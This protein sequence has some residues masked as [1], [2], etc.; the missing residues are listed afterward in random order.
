MTN[1]DSRFGRWLM[2]L[3]EGVWW[4]HGYNDKDNADPCYCI[5]LTNS[6]LEWW[7][8]EK[9]NTDYVLAVTRPCIQLLFDGWRSINLRWRTLCAL[10]QRLR[11]LWQPLTR[12]AVRHADTVSGWSFRIMR[13]LL[14]SHHVWRCNN[15]YH[16][17]NK[18]SPLWWFWL[19]TWK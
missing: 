19:I 2:L 16:G 13:I 7:V 5:C 6:C 15:G 10:W 12:H 9:M 4:S 18:V 1:C 3:S 8:E 17:Y 14:W 11:C